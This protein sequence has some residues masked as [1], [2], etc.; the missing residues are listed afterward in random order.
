M[1]MKVI[2]IFL[3]A[4]LFTISNA[5]TQ[6]DST[7]IFRTNSLQFRVYNFIS[8]SS[9]KGALLS[10]KYHSSDQN[11]F[12]FAVS[13]KARKWE[14]DESRDFFYYDTTLFN[15]N[16]DHK[17][18]AIEIIAQY[19]KYF[20]PKDEIILF[21]GIGPRAAFNIRAADNI[22][23]TASGDRYNYYTKNNDERYQLGLT[24]SFGLEWFFRKN[25]SLHAEYGVN[26]H[27]FYE[28]LARTRI[29]ADTDYPFAGEEN[30]NKRTGFELGQTGALL[31]LSIYF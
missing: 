6:S 21:F 28:E 18:L 12:R 30:S 25:M 27:Y 31:G 24:A 17:D 14:E 13:I 5:Q 22:D 20:N 1:K 15:Q 29:I 11:A 4:I 8:L 10:Y 23:V 19:L 26:A 16:R 2:F 3:L 9:F 7:K